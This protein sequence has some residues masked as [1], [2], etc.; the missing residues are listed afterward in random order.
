MYPTLSL[1]P[2]VFPTAGLVYLLGIWL[3]LTLV[4]RAAK[5]LRLNVAATYGL[6]VTGLVAGFVGA[7]LLF[8]LEYWA[9]FQANLLGII[10]PL[11][12]GY[13]LWGGLFFGVAAAFFYG[14][15]KQLPL[16]STLDALAPGLLT[17]FLTI[18]LADFLAGPGYGTLTRMPW[19]IPVFGVRRQPVQLYEVAVGLA[20]LSLW[21]RVADRRTFPGQLFLLTAILYSAGRLFVDAFRDNAWLTADG[22]HITQITALFILLSSLI[23]LARFST[24]QPHPLHNS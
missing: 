9:A 8:V 20:A 19:G 7:R 5:R 10:W 16:W 13:N 17:A 21:W 22:Y 2:F 4:E 6:T 1:G 23:L 14:R 12:N 18:S 15:Y 11:T 24:R 3:A